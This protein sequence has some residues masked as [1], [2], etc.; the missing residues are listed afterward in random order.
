VSVP[1]LSATVDRDRCIVSGTCELVAPDLFAL[2]DNGV[3]QV[4]HDPVPTALAEAA[5]AAAA[6]CPSRALQLLET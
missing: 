6:Q 2:G 5:R 1:R 4:L 3:V